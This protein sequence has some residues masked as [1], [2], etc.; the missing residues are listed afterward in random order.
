M[1]KENIK[2]EVQSLLLTL[3][4]LTMILQIVFYKESL[5]TTLKT[6]LSLFWLFMLPGFA[7]MFHY[8]EKL[9]FLQRL[10][11]GT[12]L[13]FAIIGTFSYLIGV[14]GLHIRYHSI[15]LPVL[16]IAVAIIPQVQH[17]QKSS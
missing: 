4:I 6:S 8:H 5:I 11:I 14:L 17:S 3:V 2:Q 16:L 1:F 9:D 12:G 15:L 13:G 7:L 10:I